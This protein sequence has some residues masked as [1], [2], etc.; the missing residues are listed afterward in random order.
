MSVARYC[1]R[2]ASTIAPDE[3]L[4]NAAQRI[5]KEGM[6]CLVVASEDRPMGVLTDRDLALRVLAEGRDP[7]ATSVRDV[8]RRSATTIRE[9][10]SLADAS[11]SMCREGVRRLPVVDEEGALLGVLAAGDVLRVVAGE[12]EAL[13]AVASAQ[14]PEGAPAPSPQLPGEAAQRTAGHYHKEVVCLPAEASVKQAAEEMKGQGVGCVVVTESAGDEAVGLVTDRDLVLRVIAAG[15]DPEA[16]AVSSIMSTPLAAAEPHQPLEMLLATMRT[17]S[18]RRVPVLEEGRAVGMVTFDDVL[19][20]LGR[21]LEQLGEA[22]LREIR[23]ERRDV[24]SERARAAAEE[25]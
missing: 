5:E 2:P 14:V 9:T 18:V 20:A 23:R 15:R 1:R 12:V 22:A 11:A 4:R 19:L 13:A 10:A 3:S 16:T 8:L 17:R 21:E 7:A 25:R 24:E 6:G